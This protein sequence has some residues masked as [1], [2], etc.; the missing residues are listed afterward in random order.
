M[1]D[2]W[3]A[4]KGVYGKTLVELAS[5]NPKI[6]VLEADLT[7]ASG[8]EP[9]MNK[10]PDRHINTGVAEQNLVGIAAGI[11]AMGRIPYACTMANFMSQRACDQAAMSVAY[12]KFNVKLVG[13]YAGLTQEKNGGTHISLMDLAIM[14]CLPN[15]KVIVPGDCKEFS[16]AVIAISKDKNLTYLRMPKLLINSLFGRSHKF[17]I[18]KGYQIGKGSDLTLVS[19][20]I[21][22]AIAIEA[23]LELDKE[24]IKARFIHLHTLKTVDSELLVQSARETGAIFTIENHS[25]FGGFGGLVAEVITSEFPIPVHRIG[26]SDQSGLIAQLDF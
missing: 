17:K 21:T 6:F 19:T 9:F 16:Q 24:N 26:L 1:T 5:G 12:N 10:Y 18:G 8:T 11:A 22:T 15:M 13:C 25:V 4:V 3:K 7:K 2:N 20:G 23:F 14:R